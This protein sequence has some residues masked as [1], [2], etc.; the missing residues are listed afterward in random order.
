M[1][2]NFQRLYNTGL[3]LGDVSWQIYTDVAP[4]A[5]YDLYIYNVGK[6]YTANGF[7]INGGTGP[8][9]TGFVL[10]QN[11]V[12]VT[13]MTGPLQLTVRDSINGFS[14]V[15]PDLLST[16]YWSG[17]TSSVWNANVNNFSKNLAGTTPATLP[18]SAATEV[19]FNAVGASNF[20]STTLGADTTIKTLTFGSNATAAVGIGGANTLTITPSSVKTGVTVNSGSATHTIST[21]VALGASQSWTVTDST[22]AL[23]ATGVIS[24][25]FGLTKSGEGTLVFTADHTY[26]GGTTVAVGTLALDYTSGGSRLADVGV[27]TLAGGTVNLQNGASLH[28]EVVGSTIISDGLSGVTRSSGTSV[29][30]LNAITSGL[31][32]VNF[33]ASNIADTNRTNTNG[34]LG[35]WATVAGVDWAQNSTNGANGAI[36]A[37]TAYTDI[38]AQGSTIAQ[39]PG[40]NVRLLASGVSG[41][42]ALG[43]ATTTINTLL[44]SNATIAATVELAGNSLVSN[45]LMVGATSQGLTIGGAVDDGTLA[46]VSAGGTLF[47]NNFSASHPLT[48]NAVI[49]DQTSASSLATVGRVVLAGTNT[50]TGATMVN[51]GALSVENDLGLG[52]V[53]GGTTVHRGAA[54]ELAA[55]FGVTV[56]G[57]ALSLNGMG[58]GNGGALRSVSGNNRWGGTITL[59]GASRINV[60][61]GTLTLQT[62]VNALAGEGDIL[63][64]GSG[65]GSIFGKM[66]MTS[67][68]VTKDGAGTWS[69]SGA[70]TY[71]GS[72]TLSGGTLSVAA[73]ANLGGSE[74]K[75]VFDGGNLRIV[76]TSLVNFSTIGHVVSF[77]SGKTVGLNIFNSNLAFTANAVMDQG[78]GGFSKLGVGTVVMDQ[79]NTYTGVTTIAEGVLKAETI[80]V[81]SGASN[82]GNAT[83]AVVLG[84][85]TTRGTLSFTGVGANYTR[86]FEVREGGGKIEVAASI[87]TL[88]I[89]GGGI[90]GVE[91]DLTIAGSG[92]TTITAAV[93]LGGVSGSLT[94]QGGGILNVNGGLQRYKTLTTLAGAGTTNIN[95]GLSA[96]GGTDVVAGANLSFGSVSQSLGSLTIDDGVTVTFSGGLASG[97]F[98]GGGKGVALVPEPGTMG[99]LLIGGLGFMGRRRAGSWIR[100]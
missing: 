33:G 83:S 1:D 43:A 22:Q 24:G 56:G 12:K 27:L 60:D 85:L 70:N 7:S 46:T 42:I 94:K 25:A 61:G 86:G 49:A 5:T 98:G 91:S 4:F 32:V 82:L 44:Q 19:V 78:S 69:L 88:T 2:T 84:G 23:N 68:G 39:G 79:A 21:Q 100:G 99:L 67:G 77:Q 50:Y 36:T 18:L 34:I 35:V 15:G 53:S 3:R 41:N 75:L 52:A 87:A 59:G 65:D 11:Y 74:S 54:L 92:T 62:A 17:T 47:L 95:V 63:L 58:V 90:T 71:T 29:L 38:T 16:A 26:S 55:S 97:S 10:G 31:G 57:E 89:S 93:D 9:G 6:S 20:S 76:G 51:S 28:N 13:G 40:S 80:N 64:G 14:I 45:G 81:I 72:T 37:Y 48:I 30:R 73:V 8:Q 96:V 66:V